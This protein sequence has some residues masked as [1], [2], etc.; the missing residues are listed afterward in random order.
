MLDLIADRPNLVKYFDMPLQHINNEMLKKMNRRMTR[1]KII[2]VIQNIR[3]RV[4]EAV[5]RTQ[6]IV[7]FPGE[8]DEQFEELLDF[9]K[10]YSFDRVGCFQYSI[11]EGTKAG[12]MAHQ[13]DEEVKQQRYDRLMQVQQKISGQRSKAMIGQVIPVLIEGYSEETDL[14]L[15]GRTSQQAPEIDGII[16]INEGVAEIGQIVPVKITDSHDYDLVGEMVSGPE[17]SS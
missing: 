3:Q 12:T 10:E 1:E 7:G 16:Y 17:T 14:L 13:V 9:V 8:T 5:I 2:S 6:F 15:K 11:E 4:P